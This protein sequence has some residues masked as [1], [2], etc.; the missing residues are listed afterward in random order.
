MAHLL[1]LQIFACSALFAH[2][3]ISKTIFF[4]GILIIIFLIV[5]LKVQYVGNWQQCG[6]INWAGAIQCGPGY[7]C[8]QQNPW[9]SQCQ[10][11]VRPVSGVI[12]PNNN[13]AVPQPT[14][15]TQ[16]SMLASCLGTKIASQLF[17]PR[18]PGSGYASYDWLRTSK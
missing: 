6:G 5:S 3:G 1:L 14:N 2:S 9:Y 13:P 4:L 11:E 10:P 12:V 17:S 8:Y 7:Y 18:N 15:P 16:L